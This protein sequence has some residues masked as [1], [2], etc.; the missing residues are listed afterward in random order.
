MTEVIIKISSNKILDEVLSFLKSKGIEEPI[1]VNDE[2]EDAHL[3]E[4]MGES[5]RDNKVSIDKLLT[6]RH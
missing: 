2:L 5:N 1:I 3:S 4:L 6:L